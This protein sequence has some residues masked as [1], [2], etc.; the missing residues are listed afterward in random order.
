VD[1][2]RSVRARRPRRVPGPDAADAALNWIGGERIA[3]SGVPSPQGVAHLAE[4]GVTHVVNCRPR[5]RVV[6]AG[7]GFPGERPAASGHLLRSRRHQRRRSCPAAAPG[8]VATSTGAWPGGSCCCRPRPHRRRRQGHAAP[9]ECPSQSSVFLYV[10]MKICWLIQRHTPLR[11]ASS[12]RDTMGGQASAAGQARNRCLTPAGAS[13]PGS[14]GS[15]ASKDVIDPAAAN[16]RAAEWFATPGYEAD[17]AGRSA[18]RLS[19]RVPGG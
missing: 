11:Q 3:I 16:D 12:H 7:V 9:A 4:Q 15:G 19:W 18:P 8:R 5:E 13:N 1:L 17:I 2:L 6:I 14:Q 10:P